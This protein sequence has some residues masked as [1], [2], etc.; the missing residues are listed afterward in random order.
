[1]QKWIMDNEPFITLMDNTKDL[2]FC[3]SLRGRVCRINPAVEDFLG[4]SAEELIGQPYQVLLDSLQ[5]EIFSIKTIE[6]ITASLPI[7]NLEYSCFNKRGKPQQVLWSFFPLGYKNK[8]SQGIL[9]V[10]KKNTSLKEFF[11]RRQKMEVQSNRSKIV[12]EEIERLDNIIKYV[13]GM[14]YWKDKNSIHLGCNEPFARVAGFHREDIAGKSDYDLPWCEQAAKY[15]RDDQAVI[16][17]GKP[18]LNIEDVMLFSDGRKATVI[19]NKVPLR[20]LKGQVIGVLGIA[21]DITEQK[22]AEKALFQAKM[23]AEEAS[24]AKTEFI[25]N[26]SHDVRTPVIGIIGMSQMLQESCGDLKEKEYARLLSESGEELLDLLHGVLDMISVDRVAEEELQPGC[27]PVYEKI[28]ALKKL[29]LPS[30]EIKSLELNIHIDEGIPEYLLTDGLKL[31]RILLNLLGNAIKF[32]QKGYVEIGLRCLAREEEQ[33][34]IGF[35]VKD[36]G[37]GIPKEQQT[38]IFE[39]F[40][41]TQTVYGAHRGRGLGLHI[42]Q[43]YVNLLGGEIT[44]VSEVGKG[45]TFSFTLSFKIN[46]E[47]IQPT[48]EEVTKKVQWIDWSEPTLPF[49]PVVFGSSQ[50]RDTVAHLLLVEDNHVALKVLEDMVTKAGCSYTSVMSGEQALSLAK[51]NHFDLILTDIGLPGLSGDEF[52]SALR[53]WERV[54]FNRKPIPVVAL[55]AHGEVAKQVLLDAGISEVLSKPTNLESIKKL[56][57]QFVL[58]ERAQNKALGKG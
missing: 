21:T 17:S 34:T 30:V 4:S 58:Q 40:F 54:S 33:V 28:E 22:N 5:L 2:V 46:K 32:T 42:A 53:Q 43:K 36:T 51:T 23:A 20:D 39:R 49:D 52:T 29:V 37:I 26:M 15:N 35:S 48:G 10:G 12:T 6:E 45:T 14:I 19:S 24:M 27:F 11:G 16:Q 50:D 57:G 56:I 55:S 44:V 25:A 13:P 47:D 3:L 31:H 41:R 9:L 38:K 7:R 18:R 1:M 8:M